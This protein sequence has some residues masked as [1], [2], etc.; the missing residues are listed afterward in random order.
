MT[1]M[2]SREYSPQLFKSKLT[3]EER[4]SLGQ[5]LPTPG[6]EKQCLEKSTSYIISNNSFRENDLV[7]Q[8]CLE[9][10]IKINEDL[11]V[12]HRLVSSIK[13]VESGLV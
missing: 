7:V 10:L 13:L 11:A 9:L 3:Q 8:L 5:F 4:N 12:L 1:S 6:V 2:F